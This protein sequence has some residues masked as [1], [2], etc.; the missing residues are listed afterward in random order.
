MKTTAKNYTFSAEGLTPEQVKFLKE[1][2]RLWFAGEKMNTDALL[3]AH[4]AAGFKKGD[5]YAKGS[6]EAWEY[7][8]ALYRPV[9]KTSYIKNERAE[10]LLKSSEKGAFYVN[11]FRA[12]DKFKNIGKVDMT[13][14]LE[15]AI[16]NGTQLIYE[17][18]PSNFYFEI[19]GNH[20]YLKYQSILGSRFIAVID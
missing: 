3:K 10:G 18:K 7:W 19:V 8:N 6:L 17:L 13:K 2:E 4:N 20:L 14:R 12:A 5:E 1:V 9:M 16:E 11:V 15:N